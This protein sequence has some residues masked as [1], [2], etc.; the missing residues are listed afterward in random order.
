[1]FYFKRFQPFLIHVG[2]N[3]TSMN[4][5]RTPRAL[6]RWPPSGLACLKGTFLKLR[7]LYSIH[8]LLHHNKTDSSA[9]KISAEP[10]RSS[11]EQ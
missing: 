3:C 2:R 6:P 10:G 8:S 7:H 5:N 4:R 11:N 9:K 1:M